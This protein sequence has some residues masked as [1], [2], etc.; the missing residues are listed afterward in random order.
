MDFLELVREKAALR[1]LFLPHAVRQMSRVDRKLKV[2]DIKSVIDS[3]SL[4]EE[5]PEDVRGHSGLLMGR[6]LDERL[7]HVVCSPKSEYLAVITAY[8]P[9]EKSWV[10]DFKTRTKL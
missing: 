5:Y 4:I 7:V 3:G 2:T 6:S 1:I 9:D 8:I 10:I